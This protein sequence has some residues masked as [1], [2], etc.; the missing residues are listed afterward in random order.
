MI[1]KHAA[2]YI[3][4]LFS[5]HLNGQTTLE[6][7]TIKIKEVEIKG[8]IVWSENAGFKITRIDSLL[9]STYNHNTL[10]DLISD[11]SQ[12][13]I[14]TY[15]AGGLAT[16]SFRGTG[17]GHTQL[18]WNSVNLNNPMSG[19]SDLSLAPAGLI[20][21]VVI[22]YGGGSMCMNSGG[23][24]GIIDLETKPDWTGKTLI[25]INPAAGSFGNYSG[26]LKIKTGNSRFQ[27][28]T[29]AY[30]WSAENNFNYLNNIS[31]NEPYRETRR[32]SQISQKGFLQE[33]YFKNSHNTYSARFWYQSANRNLPV[34]I[35][36]ATLNPCEKQN[37]ESLRAMITCETSKGSNDL[38][39]TAAF[40]SDKLDYKNE[41]A[42]VD[43]RNRS[44]RLLLKGDLERSINKQLSIRF[45]VSNELTRIGTNNYAGE[46]VRNMLSADGLTRITL[47]R[48][49]V[50]RILVR[51]ILLDKKLLAPD[52]S[53][54]AEI[55][56]FTEKYYY[57]K[58][59]FSKNS[60]VPALND[61]YWSPGGNP[62]LENENGFL[63]ELTLD[64]TNIISTAFSIKN[65][66]TIFRNN[67]KNMIQWHPGESYYWEADNLNNIL[68]SGLE[69]SVC[70][71]YTSERMSASLNAG[72]TYTRAS[73]SDLSAGNTL[74]SGKQLIYTPANQANFLM[75][76]D[77]Q[78]F[79]SSFNSNY[80]GKRFLTADNSQYL[81]QYAI[82]DLKLGLRFKTATTSYDAGFIIENIFNA[83][84][85][86]IAYYP[87]PGR[88]YLLSLTFQLI[89]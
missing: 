9:K 62:E 72:Y 33:L 86:N 13:Y 31:G 17:P 45:S 6:I 27:S 4:L 63:S 47:T 44:E 16:S 68:T 11:N 69:T 61:M 38:N 59:S 73:S 3:A 58:A 18:A 10:A 57:I 22:F 53:A 15:G 5:F 54:G 70:L 23:F 26:L 42:S 71:S 75:R 37:D 39:L 14:K 76:V 87:M 81:P 32:N 35:I 8:R 51:E 25:Y 21:D 24:G 85:Q 34:P 56:P 1:L 2:V 52:F 77:W 48:W 84:Y 29:K 74:S 36:A 50:A 80:T 40:I 89:K 43:S 64:M 28:V 88:S 46:I 7:D 41:V 66:I 19:Q 82:S 65:D 20:D 60:K 30:F 78:R 67:L 49:M 12:I 79:Y 83:M 55:K